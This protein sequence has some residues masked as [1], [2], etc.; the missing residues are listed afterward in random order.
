MFCLSPPVHSS[1]LW[2][3]VALPR[4]GRLSRTSP[5]KDLFLAG[6]LYRI[7]YYSRAHG[8]IYNLNCTSAC[9]WHHFVCSFF[10]L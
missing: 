10:F 3:P 2:L 9:H 4:I 7:Y 1:S 5:D 8:N 6:H